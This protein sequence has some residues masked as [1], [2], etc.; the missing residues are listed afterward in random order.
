M[1]LGIGPSLIG[2]TSGLVCNILS[3][4]WSTHVVLFSEVG[5]LGHYVLLLV[6][7]LIR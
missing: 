5:G 6:R 7:L 1:G 2:I 3:L 4:E